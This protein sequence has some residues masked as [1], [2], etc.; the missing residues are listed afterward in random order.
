MRLLFDLRATQPNPSG[1]SHGGGKYGIVVFFALMEENVEM[2]CA[3]DSRLYLREDMAEA[4]RRNGIKLI[5]LKEKSYNE[6][7]A[8]GRYDVFYSALM[9]RGVVAPAGTQKIT[10]IHGLRELEMP[11]DWWFLR[12]RMSLYET[13]KCSIILTLRSWWRGVI[14]RRNRE[15]LLDKGLKYVTVSEHTK[16]SCLTYFPQLKPDDMAVCYSPSTSTTRTDVKPY[17][18]DYKYL[19]FRK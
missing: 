4:A 14:L 17:T 12:Y 15:R 5:D 3:Y 16:Y 2:D 10:T 1:K 6:I 13:A 18:T 9:P 19:K 7:L 11:R 8:D